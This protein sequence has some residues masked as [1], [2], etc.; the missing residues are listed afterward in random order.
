MHNVSR[1]ISC[2][3]LILSGLL[4]GLAGACAPSVQTASET[5]PTT[6]SIPVA[7]ELEALALP[8]A[9]VLESALNVRLGPARL[10]ES[11]AV[12]VESDPL[13][14]H[15][16]AYDC[17]WLRITTPAGQEGWV[18]SPFVELNRPC[19]EIPEAEIPPLP[20]VTDEIL[21][22]DNREAGF[23][24]I[25]P[26]LPVLGGRQQFTWQSDSQLAAD[27]AY[28]LIFWRP[29]QDPIKHG[30][31]PVPTTRSH[32]LS[33]HLGD[34]TRSIP[35]LQFGR[36][37]LWSVALV[38]TNTKQRIELLHNGHRFHLDYFGATQRGDD[39]LPAVESPTP[40]SEIVGVGDEE[41]MSAT[42][43]SP[44]EPV[45]P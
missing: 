2:F 34:A 16:Q 29:S 26:L 19:I 5:E 6:I 20:K 40:S 12:V 39:S 41:P 11:I 14:V 33:F 44:V 17:G 30:I 45:R 32:Q 15:G 21:Q 24:L 4:V 7:D 35:Q 42:P 13:A 25:Q 43:E 18:S 38:D 36:D 9:R 31:S 23:K 37:Y 22:N 27:Q 10:Y 28:E 8:D 1:K 3:N